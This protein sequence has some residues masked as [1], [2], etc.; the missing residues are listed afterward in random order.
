M[1][2]YFLIASFFVLATAFFVYSHESV[3]QRI[4][5]AYECNDVK[6]KY[7]WWGGMTWCA[8]EGFDEPAASK[9]LNLINE[10]VGYNVEVVMLALLMLT[11]IVAYKKVELN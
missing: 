8:E 3:H 10:I 4:Y 2:V 7:Y 9:S 11:L 6:T 1:R 5:S